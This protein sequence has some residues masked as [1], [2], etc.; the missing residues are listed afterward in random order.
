MLPEGRRDQWGDT[1]PEMKKG[2]Q[3]VVKSISDIIQS[4]GKGEHEQ[5]RARTD[6][7][8]YLEMNSAYSHRL[9]VG[10][11]LNRLEAQRWLESWKLYLVET[12]PKELMLGAGR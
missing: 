10:Q 6:R 9:A 1:D 2:V 12:G 11:S 3:V 5:T 4:P 8:Y 7:C